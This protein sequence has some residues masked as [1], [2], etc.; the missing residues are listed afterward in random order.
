MYIHC[1]TISI[2]GVSHISGEIYIYLY[3]KFQWKIIIPNGEKIIYRISIGI[4]LSKWEFQLQ[5]D[6]N[7]TPWKS[8]LKS[9]RK[10][11][12][13]FPTANE[14]YLS[15]LSFIYKKSCSLG[16]LTSQMSFLFVPF[17]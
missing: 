17:L 2:I 4:S 13:I 6:L 15:K 10:I 11:I 14:N 3:K 9:G 8:I 12:N 7:K 5:K 16:F 1:I